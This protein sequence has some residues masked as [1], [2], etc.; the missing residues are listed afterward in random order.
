MP[1]PGGVIILTNA[2]KY[3]GIQRLF[4]KASDLVGPQ[5]GLV[6]HEAEKLVRDQVTRAL[7]VI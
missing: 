3:E 6:K 2:R 7:F 5:V 4:G 1:I